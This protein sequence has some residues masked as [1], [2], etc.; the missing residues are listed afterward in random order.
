[1]VFSILIIS[2]IAAALQFAAHYFPYRRL[3]G[4]EL[5]RIEAYV[6][7]LLI[8][9]GALTGWLIWQGLFTALIALWAVVVSSGLAVVAGY[10]IDEIAVGRDAQKAARALERY[11]A[12][13]DDRR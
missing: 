12:E 3:L 4:R 8:I 6:I 13:D 1:M 11:H 10:T 5:T 9:A 2:L 7:G